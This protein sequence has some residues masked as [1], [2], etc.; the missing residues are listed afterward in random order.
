MGRT[1]NGWA[2]MIVKNIF[3]LLSI[4][5]M[6][7]CST[8]LKREK[9]KTEFLSL[10][11]THKQE[12]SKDYLESLV[13]EAKKKGPK[14]VSFLASDLFLKANDTAINGDPQKAAFIYQYLIKLEPNDLF[15]QKRYALELI[16]INNLSEALPLIKNVFELEKDESIGLV[17]SGIYASL[18]QRKKAYDIYEKLIK[19]Y[20]KSVEPCLFISRLYFEEGK[21]EEVHKI[22]SRCEK[23]NKSVA[24]Y[25]YFR[26]RMALMEENI[27]KAENYFEKAIE[28]DPKDEKSVLALGIVLEEKKR[29][30]EALLVYKKYLISTPESLSVLNHYVKLLFSLERYDDAVGYAE[31]LVSLDHSN[32]NL[33]VRLGIIYTD[34][35]DLDKAKGI[36]KEVLTGFPNS[37]KV[38]YYLAS[39]YQQTG[40][41]EEALTYFSKIPM[42][43]PLFFE[44]Q[45]QVANILQ[46]EAIQNKDFENDFLSFIEK[47]RGHRELKIPFAVLLSD[48]YERK[49]QNR[50]AL[51]S[52][53]VVKNEDNFNE[54]HFFLLSSLYEKL[55][56][57]EKA[58]EMILK[59]IQK[60][61]QNANALNFL[62]Y[63]LLER[64]DSFGKAFKYISRAVKIKP[65]DGYIRDSLGWYYYRVGEFKKALVEVKKAFQL[66]QTDAIISKHLAILYKRLDKNKMAKKYLSKALKNCKTREERREVLKGIK[67]IGSWRLPASLLP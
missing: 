49:N 17:L 27:S 12:S 15:I 33:K 43:S 36:F 24:D 67:N 65:D 51:Q 55:Q 4:A 32:L 66:I 52:L 48:Y 8:A 38:L 18:N 30:N 23:N 7:S 34:A 28:I 1:P 29:N 5:G 31:T 14:A 13:L 56:N 37:D 20:P 41:S 59:I 64:G 25:S 11:K 44:G 21:K 10:K 39:L 60:N 3:L 54:N 22:L 40:D 45:I 62:G 16:K 58:D 42:D 57:Y 2:M 47:L 19:T 35:N 9:K 63:T 6:F 61:P 46:A 50:K 26:G 53:L